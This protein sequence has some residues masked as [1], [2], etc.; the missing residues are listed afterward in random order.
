MGKK[1]L[2]IDDEQD[3]IKMVELR[4]KSAGYEV[5]TA[6]DGMDGLEKARAEKP[7]LIILDVM[8]PKMNGDEVCRMLKF[9]T[10]YRKI[11]I[12]ILTARAQKKDEVR[13]MEAGADAYLQ[14]PF[15]PNILLDKIRDLLQQ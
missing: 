10:N 14:K 9:D 4:I 11:P 8:L 12:I 6:C 7:D 2:I 3:F 13:A 15:E 5:V 1:I